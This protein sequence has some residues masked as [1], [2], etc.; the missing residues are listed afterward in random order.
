MA[1]RMFK[2]PCQIEEWSVMR[3]FLKGYAFEPEAV[4]VLVQAFDAAWAIVQSGEGVTG[5]NREAMRTALAKRIVE[6]AQTGPID[7][8]VLRDGALASLG[9]Q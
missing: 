9:S 5:E 2:L 3:D 7:R 8:E 4:E 1:S 6:L